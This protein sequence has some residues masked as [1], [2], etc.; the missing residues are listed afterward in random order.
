MTVRIIQKN[1]D[2]AFATTG[3][4]GCATRSGSLLNFHFI[5]GIPDNYLE[6]TKAD[7]GLAKVMHLEMLKRGYFVAPRGLVVLSTPMDENTIN[8]FSS[9]FK[10]SLESIAEHL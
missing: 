7:K 5:K 1:I 4:D 10:D 3:I 8:G 6:V 2:N 9:A